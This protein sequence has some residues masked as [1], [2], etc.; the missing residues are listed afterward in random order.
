[1]TTMATTTP[2]DLDGLTLADVRGGALRGRPVTVLGLRPQ[3]RSRWP[4]SSRTRGPS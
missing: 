3:R 2:I 4:A 1:M